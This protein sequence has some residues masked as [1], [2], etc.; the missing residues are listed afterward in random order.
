MG[1]RN[2][3]EGAG[4]P[5]PA[6]TTQPP[7]AWLCRLPEWFPCSRGVQQERKA[8]VSWWVCL[9][10]PGGSVGNPLL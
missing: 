5:Q 8:V 1:Y 2:A 10:L 3:A 4:G 7:L 9:S 6:K